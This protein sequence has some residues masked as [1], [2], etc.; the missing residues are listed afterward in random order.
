M[1]DIPWHLVAIIFITFAI[2]VRD[3]IREAAEW[4]RR[5]KAERKAKEF[6]RRAANNPPQPKSPYL[7]DYD[8]EEE[9]E[10][11]AEATTWQPA[12][13]LKD[14]FPDLPQ[15]EEP[16]EEEWIE[17]AAQ[18]AYEEVETSK[19]PPPLPGALG[20]VD[21]EEIDPTIPSEPLKLRR[22]TRFKG[23]KPTESI[24]HVLRNSDK[25]RTAILVK[26]IL[27]KP[28]ALREEDSF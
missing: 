8:K 3:R 28:V 4:R 1:D 12:T 27:D 2:W 24:G 26:E 16:E 7:A 5:R 13:T 23:R 14:L 17:P 25:L 11:S 15:E 9:A 19:S 22:T 6:A 21:Y 20:N 10:E 18:Q